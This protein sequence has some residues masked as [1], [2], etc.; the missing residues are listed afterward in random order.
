MIS[1]NK[2]EEGSKLKIHQRI[3]ESENL[4]KRNWKLIYLDTIGL[5]ASQIKK[6][7]DVIDTF[8]PVRNKI[9]VMR[10]LI[11]EGIQTF[12]VDRMFL[13]YSRIGESFGK[14]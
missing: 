11:R 9:Q 1:K 7:N 5:A 2:I 13:A 4:I 12:N 10:I 14:H 6:I 3:V 8:S